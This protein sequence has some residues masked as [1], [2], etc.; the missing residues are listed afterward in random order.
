MLHEIVMNI[1][2]EAEQQ[3]FVQSQLASGTYVNTDD[4]INRAIALLADRHQK[5]TDLKAKIE[6]GAAQICNGQIIDGELAFQQ[7]EAKYPYLAELEQ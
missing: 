4:L 7:L 3:A 6:L 2:L 1:T 5:L